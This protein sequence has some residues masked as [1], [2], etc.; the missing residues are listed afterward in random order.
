MI[1][2]QVTVFELVSL[3]EK[4][5]TCPRSGLCIL[6]CSFVYSMDFVWRVGIAASGRGC[7]LWWT[8]RANN[9]DWTSRRGDP[10][11]GQPPQSNWG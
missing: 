11:Q 4:H 10:V 7:P 1:D 6:A 8:W 2:T 9:T 5:Y 3:G